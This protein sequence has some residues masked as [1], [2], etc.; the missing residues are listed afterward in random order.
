MS[1][2]VDR[3]VAESGV[4]EYRLRAG[5]RNPLEETPET[6]TWT[7]RTAMRVVVYPLCLSEE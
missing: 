3:R 2:I 7:V 6:D 4:V 1:R 5:P